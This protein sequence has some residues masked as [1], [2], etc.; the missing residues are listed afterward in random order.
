M[1]IE[2]DYPERIG[3]YVIRGRLAMGGMAELFVAQRRGRGPLVCVKRVLPQHSQ[4]ESFVVAFTSEI[5]LAMKLRHPNIIRVHEYGEDDGY[6]LV[7][8]LVQGPDL[9][10]LINEHGPLEPNVVA[11]IGACLARALVFI[12]HSDGERPAL[13]HSDI[14][15]HNVLIDGSGAVKLS[16]F[17]LAKALGTTGG[18]TLTKARG[19]AGYVAPEQLGEGEV[20]ITSGVDLFTLGLVVWQALIGTHPY[21]ESCPPERKL[22]RWIPAQLRTNSR[23]RVI[24]AAPMAPAGLCD[25]IEKLLQPLSTR[26]ASAEDVLAKLEAYVRPASAAALGRLASATPLEWTSEKSEV[27]ATQ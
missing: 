14:T 25:T 26:I 2:R 10:A 20:S 12:H 23:R 1:E 19:K 5:E 27:D 16:D 21:V 8:E 7:M 24:D 15:P 17:G 3:H 6:Y 13:I 9:A 4:D 18:A 22:Q 11:H